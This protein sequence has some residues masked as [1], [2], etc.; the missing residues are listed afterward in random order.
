M[1]LHITSVEDVEYAIDG[2]LFDM[3]GTIVDSLHV[4]ERIWTQWAVDHG[5]ADRLVIQHG[6]PAEATIRHAMPELDDADFERI[7]ADQRIREASDV[8]GVLAMRGT[9]DLMEW[10]TAEGIAWAVVTSAD[11]SLASARLGAAGIYP[12]ALVTCDDITHGKPHPE[13]FL[14]GATR[15]AVTIDRCLVVEDT[16]AGLASGRAAGAR[17]AALGG[18]T[19]DLSIIDMADLHR[20][21]LDAR[22]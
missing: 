5:V 3:D 15:I 1:S 13:P 17:T 10:L 7:L 2:V 20:Q 14:L 6:Q 18:L 22:T 21:L 8:D 11:A 4:T 12:P 16:E 9:H 19:G